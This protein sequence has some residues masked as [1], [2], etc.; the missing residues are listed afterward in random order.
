MALANTMVTYQSAGS[1]PGVIKQAYVPLESGATTY[2]IV[3]A[4]TGA[5][6][7]VLSIAIDTNVASK[8]EFK[9]QA[10]VIASFTMQQNTNVWK[11]SD[12]SERPLFCTNTGNALLL[13]MSGA[14]NAGG[15]YVQW[16]E[17]TPTS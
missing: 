15:V 10:D 1:D 6:I 4:V 2:T 11:H 16:R 5:Q 3:E 9:S 14:V 17:R 12:N 13:T 8:A 7:Q